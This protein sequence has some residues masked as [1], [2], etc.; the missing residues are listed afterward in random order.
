MTK[1]DPK[2]AA[3]AITPLLKKDPV[4]AVDPNTQHTEHYIEKVCEFLG[5]SPDVHVQNHIAALLAKAGIEPHMADEYPKALSF[6]NKKTGRLVPAVYPADHANAGQV[7][8]FDTEDDESGYDKAGVPDV[9][10]PDDDKDEPPKVYSEYEL[11][12]P[13]AAKPAAAPAPGAA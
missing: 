2:A 12:G 8:V 11:F 13:G 10:I 9:A 3:E 5:L 4:P 1:L 7:V 6:K